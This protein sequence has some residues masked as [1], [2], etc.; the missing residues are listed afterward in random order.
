MLKGVHPPP[1]PLS[2]SNSEELVSST[3]AVWLVDRMHDIMQI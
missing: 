2:Q 1:P 3:I